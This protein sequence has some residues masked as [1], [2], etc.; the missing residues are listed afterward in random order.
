MYLVNTRSDIQ[1]AVHQCA[2][3]THCPKVSHAEAVRR[4]SRYLKG[5]CNEG[6]QF[7]PK[8]NEVLQLD[9]Y[10]DGFQWAVWS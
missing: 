3:F 5:T 8:N 7:A 2:R 6:P 9:C 1:F 4:I 10:V